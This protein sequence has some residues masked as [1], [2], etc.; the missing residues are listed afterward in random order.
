MTLEELVLNGV[1]CAIRD[2]NALHFDTEDP[3]DEK[4]KAR[5][6]NAIGA[7]PK[8]YES[9]EKYFDIDYDGVVSLKPE[10]RGHPAK[11]TYPY[12][13]SD[14]G[15][16]VDGSK[17]DELP[18]KIVVPDVIAGTAV[19]GFQPGVLHANERIR[20]ITIPDAVEE[21]PNYFCREAY[22]LSA[23]FGTEGITKVSGSS[24]AYTRVKKLLFPN[25]KE[26]AAGAFG[27]CSYLY[28]IDIGDNITEIPAMAF[29]QCCNLSKVKGGAKVT[30]IGDQA[31]DYTYNLKN[32]PLL[33]GSI[34]S[35]G[36]YAFLWSRVQF[37]WSTLKNCT[38]GTQATP[39]RDNTTDYWSSVTPKPC[40]NPIGTVMSQINPVWANLIFGDSNITYANCC[41]VFSIMHIHSALSGKTYV[42]PDEFAEELRS[43]DPSLLTA[44]KHPSNFDNVAPMLN[45]L[46][47]NTTVYKDVI[48]Q[49]SYK[50][51]CDALLRGAYIYQVVSTNV[52]VNAGHVVVLYGINDI[53]E[54][55]FV[56]SANMFEPYR[57][58]GNIEDGHYQKAPHQN[59]T[60]PDCNFVIVEKNS[61]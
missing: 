12:A 16:G 58:T 8:T 46:G 35:I 36:D 49:S 39:V 59:I 28:A 30:K 37:D 21:L 11:N 56:D 7:A 17:I 13:I 60:G 54:M 29:R 41:A 15:V 2:K 53:G 3:L 22:N 14:N 1:P 42:H 6:R 34:T 55:M 47:Y 45:A 48:T 19:S 23:V 26:M 5:V 52:S 43:I 61:D 4:E 32:L 27:G 40:K 33:S 20:E 38:F 18:E 31:F 51:L 50:D 10:Y 57:A 25:L 9:D 24:F 44:D